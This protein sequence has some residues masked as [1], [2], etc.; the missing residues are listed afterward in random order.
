MAGASLG[1]MFADTVTCFE[2]EI[3]IVVTAVEVP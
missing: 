2:T 1:L 3:E